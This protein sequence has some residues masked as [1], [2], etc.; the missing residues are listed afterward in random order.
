VSLGGAPTALYT[1]APAGDYSSQTPIWLPTIPADVAEP[2]RKTIGDGHNRNPAG[3]RSELRAGA[4]PQHCAI[5]TTSPFHLIIGR[6]QHPW[7]MARGRT[8]DP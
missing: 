1:A 6:E 3:F 4:R 7:Q 8:G 5:V 2:N